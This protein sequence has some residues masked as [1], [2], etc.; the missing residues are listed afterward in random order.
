MVH[1]PYRGQA[2]AMTDLFGGQVQVMF[3]PVVSS[4]AHIRAGKLRPLAEGHCRVPKS[5]K[6][7]G[8]RLGTWITV[9]R[10]NREAMSDNRRQTL[11]ELG[12]VWDMGG[13][14]AGVVSTDL[15]PLSEIERDAARLMPK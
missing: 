12:F 1:V 6:E 4:I 3:D 13:S 15:I 14:A 2:P 11:N 10:R 9:Q 5:H 8:F 7:N